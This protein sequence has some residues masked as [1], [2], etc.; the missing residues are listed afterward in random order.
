MFLYFWFHISQRFSHSFTQIFLSSSYGSW[1]VA[2]CKTDGGGGEDGNEEMTSGP[3]PINYALPGALS[4]N[5]GML[6]AF[7]C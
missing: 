7:W 6:R 3:F 5:P 4:V 1:D 2:L